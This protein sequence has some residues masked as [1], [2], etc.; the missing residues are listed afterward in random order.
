ML[1]LFSL[2][3]VS[4]SYF[5]FFSNFISN[6]SYFIIFLSALYLGE[7]LNYIFRFGHLLFSESLFHG[8]GSRGLG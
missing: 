5:E 2:P 6:F 1:E 3:S 4:N 8:W 7:F